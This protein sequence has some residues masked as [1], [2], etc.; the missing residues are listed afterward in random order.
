MV[1][2]PVPKAPALPQTPLR[3]FQVRAVLS[4]LSTNRPLP[5]ALVVPGC[6][7]S[8]KREEMTRSIFLSL[9][10]LH[11][12]SHELEQRKSW[13]LR[14]PQE[15]EV[16]SLPL[17]VRPSPGFKLAVAPA[18]GLKAGRRRVHLEINSQ[19]T[20]GSEQSERHVITLRAIFKQRPG[21]SRSGVP[22]QMTCHALDMHVFI[23]LKAPT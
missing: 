4:H 1:H 8:L 2:V 9:K 16:T 21:S 18:L 3:D 7:G 22:L 14:A 6:S 10:G 20:S 19:L 13:E 12:W 15:S 17:F 23:A 5:L 11:P